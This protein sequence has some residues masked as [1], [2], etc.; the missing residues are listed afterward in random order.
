MDDDEDDVLTDREQLIMQL[1]YGDGWSLRQIARGLGVTPASVYRSHSSALLHL[2]AASG[3]AVFDNE[4]ED[5]PAGHIQRQPVE[6]I[7]A[8][9]AWSESAR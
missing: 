5:D 2:A 9:E 8:R 6:W 3:G 1:H 7:P 4:P